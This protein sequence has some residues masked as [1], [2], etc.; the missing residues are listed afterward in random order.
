MCLISELVD[1]K[2]HHQNIMHKSKVVKHEKDHN[3]FTDM[4]FK[5]HK[6][7]FKCFKNVPIV[8][9]QYVLSHIEHFLPY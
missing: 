8:F 4:I 7:C 9:F 1:S 3:N 6:A 5:Y 2:A